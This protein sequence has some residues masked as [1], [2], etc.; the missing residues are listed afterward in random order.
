MNRP[1]SSTSANRSLSSGISGA[2]CALTST[3]GITSVRVYRAGGPSTPLSREK[4]GPSGY[5]AERARRRR[6]TCRATSAAATTS[7]HGDRDVRV[8]ESVWKLSQLAPAAQP[9]PANAKH[10]IAE[11][12]SVR[13]GVAAERRLEDPGRDRD[14]RA[15]DGRDPAEEDGP[16]LPAV[17]PCLRT[18]EL[19]VVEVEPPPV[20]LEIRP[21]SA[22]PDLPA[23][24][25]PIR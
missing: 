15:H 12:I 5:P 21:P 8:A 16:V 9:A 24:H 22:T 13:I 6:R 1:D 7:E 3:S 20:P 2:Y 14:E 25:A 18:L 11:P 19:G 4:P 23:E 17:E 10:Q